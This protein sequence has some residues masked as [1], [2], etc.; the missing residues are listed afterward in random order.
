MLKDTKNYF[1]LNLTFY[2]PLLLCNTYYID[3]NGRSIEGYTFWGIDGRPLSEVLMKLLTF[4]DRMVDIFPFNIIFSCL[5]LSVS[6]SVLRNFLDNNRDKSKYS[7]FIPPLI[8]FNIFYLESASYRF[9]SITISLAIALCILSSVYLNNKRLDFL[10]V[11]LSTISVLSLYQTVIN[12]LMVL[13]IS[14][15]VVIA[16]RESDVRYTV[17][18]ALLKTL[19]TLMGASVYYFIVLPMSLIGGHGSDHPS[20]N[21]EYGYFFEKIITKSSL[22]IDV[23]SSYLS[24]DNGVLIL[25]VLLSIAQ[26]S[27]FFIFFKIYKKN[28]ALSFLIF[29]APLCSLFFMMGVTLLLDNVLRSARIYISYGALV[30]FC[31]SVLFIALPPKYKYISII[32]WP[33]LLHSL[34]VSYAYGNVMRSQE[35]KN[36]QTATAIY[37][38]TFKLE[39][40]F[41][42]IFN[43]EYPYAAV[44]KNT[45]SSFPQMR[46]LLPNYFANWWW[47][48]QFLRRNGFYY[49]FPQGKDINYA[50]NELDICHDAYVIHALDFDSYIKDDFAI[51]DFTKGVCGMK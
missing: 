10:I 9:D 13:I 26:I 7:F 39:G 15:T 51:I 18:S 44:A 30:Y 17:I 20:I 27:C 6:F 31:F 49:E 1:I 23:I 46:P 14:N 29:I 50:L 4:S 48:F 37:E 21:L 32:C 19:A 8:I 41:K 34:I 5:V 22:I 43:G 33:L 11:F 47:S 24:T 3:D 25:I 12:V 35:Q 38:K 16:Y 2:I 40:S 28:I 36:I 42:L 45:L